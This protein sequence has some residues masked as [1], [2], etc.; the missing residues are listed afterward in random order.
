VYF[1]RVRNEILF[2]QTEEWPTSTPPPGWPAALGV[3][4]WGLV[5]SSGHF[6]KTFT[7]LNLGAERNRGVEL[8]VDTTLTG[9]IGLFA[10]YSYQA[11]P[12]VNFDPLETNHPARH[13]VNAG[14][15]YTDELVIASLSASSSTSAF[16]QDVLDARFHGTTPNWVV[17]NGSL[18]VKFGIDDRWHALVKATN[19]LNRE[20]Q[21]H[22]FGDVIK[23]QVILELQVFLK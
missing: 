2:T 5:Q 22:I 10:N 23:R 20:V 1:S 21:Q 14:V 9:G 15:S 19:L 17:V 7:Y 13:R 11:D 16:W 18:G 6:P 8:G 3:P 4:A 12:K